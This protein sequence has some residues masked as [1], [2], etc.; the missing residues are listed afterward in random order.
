M[1]SIIKDIKERGQKTL[2]LFFICSGNIC[3]SPM[4]EILCEQILR[5]DPLPY[6]DEVIIKSGAVVYSWT[7][8]MDDSAESVLRSHYKIP[9]ARLNQFS[10]CHINRDSSRCRDADLIITM[11]TY[12]AH[13]IPEQF[14]AKTFTLRELAIGSIGDVDDPYGGDLSTY[15][16]TA[17]E[18]YDYLLLFLKKLKK[19]NS[20]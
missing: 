1:E 4:A 17:E 14:R 16:A 20:E 18:I 13:H 7:G 6:F 5:Q 10:S 19:I 8:S 9:Q 11:E 12:H 3:R 2:Y 15:K